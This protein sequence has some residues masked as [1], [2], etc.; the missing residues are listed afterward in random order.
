MTDRRT[1]LITC[2]ST[3]IGRAAALAFARAGHHVVVTDVL[4]EQ[5]H[6]LVSMIQASGGTASFAAMDVR[7]KERGDEVIAAVNAERGA[8]DVLVLNADVARKVPLEALDDTR[9]DYTLDIDLKG[10][11]RVARAALPATRRRQSGS[12]VC[13]TIANGTGLGLTRTH[14]LLGGQ[15]WC[16]RADAWSRC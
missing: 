11:F 5:G 3:G 16:Y 14:A 15:V 9:W 4:E 1:V 7:S 12:V 6:E 2:G 8:I 10:M 13:L